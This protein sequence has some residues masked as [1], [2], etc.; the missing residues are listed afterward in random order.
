MAKFGSEI[1]KLEFRRAKLGSKMG[2]VGV[3]SDPVG[4]LI[5]QVKDL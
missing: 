5:N 1:S 4:V 2:L 3:Q